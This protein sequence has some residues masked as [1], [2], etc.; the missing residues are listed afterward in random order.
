MFK[1]EG[2]DE[3]QKELSE[4]SKAMEEMDG[5]LGSVSLNP[6]DP[7]SIEAAIS[8]TNQMID[9]K[10]GSYSDNSIIGPMI[11]ELKEK[12]RDSLLEKAAEARLKGEDE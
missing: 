5:E 7:S 3:L 6:H 4:A 1:I 9:E 12:Y 11:E 8:R 2:L 10:L